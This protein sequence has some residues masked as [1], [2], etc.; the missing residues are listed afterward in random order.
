[1]RLP[2]LAPLVATLA[3]A[4]FALPA[5]G[6]DE[7]PVV[8]KKGSGTGGSG[9]TT[10]SG[11]GAGSGGKSARAFDIAGACDKA[12]MPVVLE[13]KTFA[14]DCDVWRGPD[15]VYRV[16]A[17]LDA[18]CTPADKAS[19]IYPELTPKGKLLYQVAAV[20]YQQDMDKGAITVNLAR[21]AACEAA[22]TAALPTLTKC[23]GGVDLN[24]LLGA[25]TD[26][27]D[28]KLAEGTK[29][30]DTDSCVSPASCVG[31]NSQTQQLGTCKPPGAIGSFCSN[32][33]ERPGNGT[34]RHPQCA[35][36]ATCSKGVCIATVA[37][38][39]A[40]VFDSACTS[41]RCAAGSCAEALPQ[42]AAVGG[43]CVAPSDCV[44]GAQCLGG[45]CVDK[46]GGGAACVEG[47]DECRV[48][49]EASK[50]VGL[51]CGIDRL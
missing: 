31:A 43:A 1:M 11:G 29:C 10:P 44:A 39:G 24:A 19:S 14:V 51:F 6:G 35:A 4:S 46:L 15:A 26:F 25:C 18:C 28:G 12:Q 21:V 8:T 32:T 49:C 2:L 41:G 38:G 9:G 36:G 16:F 33:S 17:A 30:P 42:K 5:C 50:C 40:C 23:A 34:A 48:F 13:G 37:N 45:A 7:A 20:L 22:V 27:V 47:G 3:L